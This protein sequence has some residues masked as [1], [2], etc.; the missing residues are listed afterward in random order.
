MVRVPL[1][2]AGGDRDGDGGFEY[3]PEFVSRDEEAFLLGKV[4]RARSPRS[5]P[6]RVLSGSSSRTAGCST[7]AGSWRKSRARCSPSRCRRS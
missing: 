6:H 5:T 4:R 7:G 3:L 2:G 1:P